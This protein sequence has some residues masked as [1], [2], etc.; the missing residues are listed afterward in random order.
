MKHL[1][2]ATISY[3]D[4]VYRPAGYRVPRLGELYIGSDGH[5]KRCSGQ[6]PRPRLGMLIVREFNADE[7]FGAR[8]AIPQAHQGG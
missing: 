2:T 5:I 4:M 8:G 6:R 1:I 3:K 7:D